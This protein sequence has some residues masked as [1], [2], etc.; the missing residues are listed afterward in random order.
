MPPRTA[1]GRGGRGGRGDRGRGR[2]GERGGGRGF[3]GEGRGRGDR[4][5]R[6]APGGS[7]CKVSYAVAHGKD[8]LS[9]I[10]YLRVRQS[11]M[12]PPPRV[13]APLRRIA[14]NPLSLLPALVDTVP[15]STQ[16][17]LRS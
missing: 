16:P 10:K 8:H 15:H 9:L 14:S 17:P 1:P 4:G 3:R 6:G 5:N 11:Y 13:L 12:S 7:G 2:G